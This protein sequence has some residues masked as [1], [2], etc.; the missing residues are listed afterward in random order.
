[1]ECLLCQAVYKVVI[2]LNLY[3]NPIRQV[4]YGPYFMGE[5]LVII[6]IQGQFVN[7][8]WG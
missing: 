3:N 7:K 8:W 6:T 5:E 1:M 2:S 4:Y